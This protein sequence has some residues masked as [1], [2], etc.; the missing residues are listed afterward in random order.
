MPWSMKKTRILQREARSGP[1]PRLISLA[2][3]L[4]AYHRLQS[5]LACLA[6]ECDTPSRRATTQG[7]RV[8][9]ERTRLSFGTLGN[10]GFP[11]ANT[12][13][14]DLEC[15]GQARHDAKGSN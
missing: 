7:N 13:D 1:S 2:E 8:H 4:L 11:S 12:G 9:R 14:D 6:N 3:H 10:A 15:L 5:K